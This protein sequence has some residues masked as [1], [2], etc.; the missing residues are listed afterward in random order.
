LERTP[1]VEYQAEY[2]N[3]AGSDK[4]NEAGYKADDLA[5]SNAVVTVL[6]LFWRDLTKILQRFS[7]LFIK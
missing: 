5:R 1:I 3:D 7:F 4:G 6:L 2:P